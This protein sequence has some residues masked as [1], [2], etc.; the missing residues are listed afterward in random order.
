MRRNSVAVNANFKT[1]TATTGTYN[2][3]YAKRRLT[4]TKVVNRLQGIF[5]KIAANA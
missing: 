3:N 1:E 4:A 5:Q 2:H